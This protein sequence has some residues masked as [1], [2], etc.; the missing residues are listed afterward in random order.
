MVFIFRNVLQNSQ[1]LNTNFCCRL[2]SNLY[3][4]RFGSDPSANC[5]TTFAKKFVTFK[6]AINQVLLLESIP[7]DP[8]HETRSSRTSFWHTQR[9][10]CH[11]V[12]FIAAKMASALSSASSSVLFWQMLSRI[13][14]HSLPRVLKLKPEKRRN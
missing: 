4:L 5:F 10:G 8:G 1:W 3:V 11:Y 12:A 9:D 7:I 6:E 14:A 2:D 13:I